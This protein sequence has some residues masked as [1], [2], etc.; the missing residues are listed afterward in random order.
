MNRYKIAVVP[1]D[2]IGKEVIPEGMKVL[3]AVAA[4]TRAFHLEVTEYPWGCEHYMETGEVMPTN[5]LDAL[6]RADAIYF[7]SAG[8]PNISPPYLAATELVFLIRQAFDQYANVRPFM[9]LPGVPTPPRG[10]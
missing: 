1:G 5:G 4:A 7:G 3:Q 6:R 9:Q 2:G 8:L 10:R